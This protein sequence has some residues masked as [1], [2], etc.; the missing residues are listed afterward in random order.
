MQ[1][2]TLAC[3][4]NWR[5]GRSHVD[6]S[7][8]NLGWPTGLEPATSRTTIWGSTIELRPPTERHKVEVQNRTVK[9]AVPP[10]ARI[11]IPPPP[12]PSPLPKGERAGKRGPFWLVVLVSR[13]T[14][15]S[16]P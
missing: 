14:V 11:L 10:G 6:A 13:C 7:K 1:G 2:L 16:R 9:F 8:N 4:L 15:E 12:S 3:R 5:D